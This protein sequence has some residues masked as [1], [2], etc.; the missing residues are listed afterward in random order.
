MIVVVDFGSQTANLIERRIR[1]LGVTTKFLP[2]EEALEFIKKNR[3]AGIILSGGPSS[4][5]DDGSPTIDPD[6]FK[7]G[8][9]LLAICYGMQLMMLLDGG[10][11]VSGKKNTVRLN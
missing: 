6:I 10:Q 2:P 3:P 4:V 7:L 5:Y 8:I 1:D 9:P 11:V